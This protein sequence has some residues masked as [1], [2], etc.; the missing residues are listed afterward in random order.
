MPTKQT[1][2]DLLTRLGRARITKEAGFG[3]QVLSRASVDDKMPSHWFFEIRR[4]CE[5][6]GIECP[7]HLFRSAKQ[8]GAVRNAATVRDDAA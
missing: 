1:V 4:M 6:D 7:E 8:R 2:S 3:P 5:N